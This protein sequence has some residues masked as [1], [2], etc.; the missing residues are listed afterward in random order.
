LQW[1]TDI[2]VEGRSKLI[3][4]LN[5]TYKSTVLDEGHQA[6]HLQIE[7]EIETEIEMT[8]QTSSIMELEKAIDPVDSRAMDHIGR[9]ENE[10]TIAGILLHLHLPERNEEEITT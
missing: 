3:F 5:L 9:L 1:E 7:T 8:T 2:Q 6:G 10:K 4:I